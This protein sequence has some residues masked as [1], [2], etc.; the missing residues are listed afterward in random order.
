MQQFVMQKG[1]SASALPV[2]RNEDGRKLLES[3]GLFEAPPISLGECSWMSESL[4]ISAVARENR[5]SP[6]R[7]E[8]G[9]QVNGG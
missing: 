3:F 9:L 4:R 8:D 7:E 1:Q 5:A 2:L 6:A